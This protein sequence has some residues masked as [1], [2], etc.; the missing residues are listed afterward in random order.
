MDCHGQKRHVLTSMMAAM[1]LFDVWS[2]KNPELIRYTWGR[3]VSARRIDFFLISFALIAKITQVTIAERFR[4][5]HLL[6][7]LKLSFADSDRGERLE[8]EPIIVGRWKF[9]YTD[10]RIYFRFFSP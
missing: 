5:D 2:L 3:N 7:M 4:S 1:D 8:M 9:H 6:I 10:K